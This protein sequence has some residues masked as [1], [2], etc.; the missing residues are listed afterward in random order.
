MFRGQGV[1]MLQRERAWDATG[2]VLGDIG[3]SSI[4]SMISYHV[5]DMYNWV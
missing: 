4:T 1:A 5:I 3:N 2:M